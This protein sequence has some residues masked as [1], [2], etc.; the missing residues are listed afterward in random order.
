MC[1][2]TRREIDALRLLAVRWTNQEIAGHFQIS[3]RTVESHVASIL[4]KLAVTNR[5]EAAR[6]A[7]QR[8]LVTHGSHATLL[9]PTP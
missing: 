6:I 7:L 8:E 3:T 9:S 2:L 4:A 1:E 5:R